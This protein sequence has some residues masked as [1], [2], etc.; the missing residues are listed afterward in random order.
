MSDLLKKVAVSALA[1]ATFGV[2]AMP[3]SGQTVAELQAQIASLLAQIQSLQAQL[4]DGAS[5]GT[6]LACYGWAQ[7]L[8]L[9]STGADVQALQQFL[10]GEGYTVASSGAGS[11]GMESTY[12]GPLTKSALASFQAAN[13]IS[14]AVG[15]FGPITR[16][17]IASMCSA[18]TGDTD[19][20]DT[21]DTDEEDTELS[22]GEGLVENFELTG[23][24]AAEDIDEGENKA[25][26][27]FMLD[28]EDSD[29]RMERLYVEVL[30]DGDSYYPWR[31]FDEVSVYRGSDEILSKDADSSSDWSE[32][33]T[34]NEY[35]MSITG[36][37]EVI[38][39]GVDQE[40]FYVYF[41]A[42]DSIDSTYDGRVFTVYIP[43]NGVRFVDAED[44][45]IYEPSSDL[46]TTLTVNTSSQVTVEITSDNDDNDDRAVQLNSTTDKWVELLDFELEADG[47]D[48]I[49]KDLAVDLTVTGATDV[50]HLVTS[51]KLYDED[52]DVIK[53]E[54]VSTSSSQT[55]TV[56]FDDIDYELDEGIETFTV[57]GYIQDANSSNVDDGDTILLD[58]DT[59]D[60]TAEDAT[61]RDGIT[62]SGSATGGTVY[63]YETGIFVTLVSTSATEAASDTSGVADEGTFTIKFNVEAFGDDIY[64]GDGTA[65]S[66]TSDEVVW[67]TVA[68]ESTQGAVSADLSTTEANDE[69]YSYKVDQG[70][71]ADF[72]L[73]VNVAGSGDGE[74]VDITLAGLDWA[75][76][77]SADET[78]YTDYTI[79]LSDFQT[80]ALNLKT[81]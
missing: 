67:Y 22:G 77:D 3:A 46:S 58:I 33:S 66:D 65:T 52:G 43:Q 16:S 54:A 53:T 79:N 10:N 45:N 60:V 81:P 78:V 63:L 8:T 64:I 28:A 38:E 21:G 49:I 34:N 17:Y 14:P 24:P 15:Y 26:I 19:T 32:T 36:L 74:F 27:G 39:D 80:D 47:G 12:F 73:T 51:L 56:T 13:G 37:D 61:T 69:T 48:A 76:S 29:L 72:T 31:Y 4:N 9:G 2:F 1:V 40:D 50:D 5:S 20:G 71:D 68:N 55:G 41:S 44:I 62:E 18:D 30:A 59:A 35:R 75:T 11:P 7:D 25:V 70:G 42:K 6:G 23:S 57:E